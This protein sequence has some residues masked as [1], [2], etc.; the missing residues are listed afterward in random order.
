MNI[1]DI[2]YEVGFGSKAAF[3]RAFRRARNQSAAEFRKSSVKSYS[4]K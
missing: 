3:N 4:E 1:L 2:G